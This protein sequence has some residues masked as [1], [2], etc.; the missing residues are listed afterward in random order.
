MAMVPFVC[1]KIWQVEMRM[2]WSN[3]ESAKHV[4]IVL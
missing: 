2:M 4:V 3:C 1:Y